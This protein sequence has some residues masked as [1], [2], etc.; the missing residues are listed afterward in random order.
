MSESA[1]LGPHRLSTDDE[2][3]AVEFRWHG[4]RFV[5]R[6]LTAGGE[7]LSSVDGS[8]DEAWPPSPPLQQLSPESTG[9]KTLIFGVGLAGQSHWSVSVEVVE[10]EGR[11]ALKFDWA[12]R[13]KQPPE[14]LGTTY[15]TGPAFHVE[16]SPG[17]RLRVTDDHQQR[18]EPAEIAA[19][20]TH[21]W[22]YTIATEGARS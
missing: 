16:P 6:V 12:C 7:Q 9:D 4:D 19:A 3:L 8:E 2:Q 5:H 1:P 17:T 10:Q 18:L 20:G 14:R 13:C 15:T 21:Q 11:P 22:T